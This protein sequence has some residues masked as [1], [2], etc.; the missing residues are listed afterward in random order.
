MPIVLSLC[1]AV[2][3]VIKKTETLYVPLVVVLLLT[4]YF[5]LHFEWLMPQIS[6]RYTGDFIDVSLYYLGALLFYNLQ[7]KLF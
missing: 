2:S 6:T 3:R 7:K 1:L 5:S 4:T